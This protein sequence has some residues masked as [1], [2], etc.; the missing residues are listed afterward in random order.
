M[1]IRSLLFALFFAFSAQIAIG[2]DCV[3]FDPI[4]VG[5][6]F[7]DGVNT[8]GEQIFI[9]N[10]IPVFVEWF[11]FTPTSG[12]FGTGLVQPSVPLFGNGHIMILNNLNLRFSFDS[13]AYI[14]K[15]VTFDFR[16]MGGMENLGISGHLPYIG[17]L[18]S[19]IPP[20]G[21]SISYSTISIPGG[22]TGTMTI[23]GDNITEILVGGQEFSLD[24]VCA[25]SLTGIEDS[26]ETLQL[27]QNYP[28]PVIGTTKIP[29][30]LFTSGN[31]E[32]RI[33]NSLG[34]EIST[35]TDQF[36]S[37]GNHTVE[38]DG[39]DQC[40]HR[41]PYGFYLYQLQTETTRLIKKMHLIQ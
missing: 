28:N 37:E 38:W 6:P 35:I 9:E 15:K 27:G 40:G 23:T 25:F 26:Y 22:I 1:K 16:D 12:M 2:Q 4:A 39:T 21:Y 14:V 18:T 41:V 17:E 36:Y 8:Q 33:L 20:S 3:T 19:A 24:H 34:Q 31:V 5:T 30:Q 29:F 11:E 7:G 10:N 32:I 13:L